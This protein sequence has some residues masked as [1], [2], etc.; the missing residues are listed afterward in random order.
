MSRASPS[1]RPSG[2]GQCHVGKRQQGHSCQHVAILLH[3]IDD[4][5]G[6]IDSVPWVHLSFNPNQSNRRTCSAGPAESIGSLLG[7]HYCMPI[8]DIFNSLRAGFV[9]RN[10]D[11][12]STAK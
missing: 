9:T 10:R 1:D 12:R 2:L 6:I 7:N 8:P 3:T 4:P 11:R 5:R